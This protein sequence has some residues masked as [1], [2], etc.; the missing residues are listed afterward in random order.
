MNTA[1]FSYSMPSWNLPIWVDVMIII[2]AIAV[3]VAGAAILLSGYELMNH[4]PYDWEW[5]KSKKLKIYG[6][7]CLLGGIIAVV[8]T[9]VAAIAPTYGIDEKE[10]VGRTAAKDICAEY[11]ISNQSDVGELLEEQIACGGGIVELGEVIV[12]VA[13]NDVENEV[14]QKKEL[15]CDIAVSSEDIGWFSREIEVAVSMYEKASGSDETYKP[16]ATRSSTGI[17]S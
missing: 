16:Y 14:L 1:C 5:V 4:Y 10:G 2:I 12:P 15:V 17:P 11:R 8:I 13:E 3:V 6:W 7:G 9:L